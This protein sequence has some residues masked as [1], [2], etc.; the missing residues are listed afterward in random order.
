MRIKQKTKE[1]A[2]IRRQIR[3]A[4]NWHK[5]DNGI[6]HFYTTENYKGSRRVKGHNV[7]FG[8]YSYYSKSS[9]AIEEIAKRIYNK[10]K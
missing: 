10:I 1:L 4:I 5:I 3:E 8:K 7:K 2:Y 6:P 9:R